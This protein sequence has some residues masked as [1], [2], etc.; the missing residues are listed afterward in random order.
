ATIN[1]RLD[2]DTA[3]LI[4]N[5]FGHRLRRVSD[6]DIE[7]GLEGAVHDPAAL[8]SRPPIVTVMGH[9]DHGKTSLLDAMRQTD[10]AAHEAGRSPQPARGSRGPPPHAQTIP[11]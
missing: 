9:V 6:S 8:R 5:E 3:E 11:L 1:E 7:L 4:V 10:V 2:P